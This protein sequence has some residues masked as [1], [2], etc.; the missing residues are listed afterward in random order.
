M[1][2][3][4]ERPV[5]PAAAAAIGRVL[6]RGAGVPA[7]RPDLHGDL[8]GLAAMLGRTVARIHAVDVP[9]SALPFDPLAGIERRLAAGRIDPHRLPHPYS[10]YSPGELVERFRRAPAAEGSSPV[11]CVGALTIDRLL[12]D[13]DE[14]V[15]ITGGGFG[16]VADRHAD[17]AVAQ[18]SIFTSLG[19]DAVFGFYEA[20]RTQ[21]NII[22]LDRWTLAGHLL[23]W[24][25]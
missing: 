18:Q 2:E 3:G 11:C 6:G 1:D 24:L 20:Y 9:D 13:G 16:L 4:A 21:P 12:I 17:L 14:L 7:D 10:S 23:G 25:P 5:D 22:E 15:G 19:G 8:P